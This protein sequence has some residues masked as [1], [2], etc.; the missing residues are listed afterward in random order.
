MKKL[1]TKAGAKNMLLFTMVYLPIGY[2]IKYFFFETITSFSYKE[3]GRLIL[4]GLFIGVVLTLLGINF[5][6]KNKVDEKL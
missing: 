1:F 5:F 4:D 3:L 2:G 6:I